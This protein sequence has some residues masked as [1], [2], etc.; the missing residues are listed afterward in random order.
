VRRARWL[1]GRRLLDRLPAACSALGQALGAGA[2]VAYL[3]TACGARTSGRGEPA[4]SGAGDQIPA[5]QVPSDAAASGASTRSA[6]EANASL[7]ED[8]CVLVRN[9]NCGVY[10]VPE[11]CWAVFASDLDSAARVE[12][13][14]LQLDLF[15]CGLEHG[16]RCARAGLRWND[17]CEAEVVAADDCKTR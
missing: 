7:L 13:T 3:L 9:A 1:A 12:C 4:P 8:L 6:S 15:R 10:E 16:V 2:V 11:E 14:E 17:G 5:D